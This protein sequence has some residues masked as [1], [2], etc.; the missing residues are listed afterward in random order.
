MVET[1]G[2][3]YVVK[4]KQNPQHR[5]VIINEFV[6]ARLLRR[7]GIASPEF[8]LVR[9]ERR[10]LDDNPE[11]AISGRKGPVPVGVGLHFGSRVPVNP[12]K[13]A[14]F[15][16]I[17]LALLSRVTN[18]AD[19]LKVFVFDLWVDN[20]DGRQAIFFRAGSKDLSALMIDNGFAFGFD[21]TEWRMRDKTICKDRHLLSELYVSEQSARIFE[22]TIPRIAATTAADLEA[23]R[24]S[25]PREWVEDDDEQLSHVFAELN[26]RSQR[27]PI[28]LRQA[29]EGL[30][31]RAQSAREVTPDKRCGPQPGIPRQG[32]FIQTRERIS[33]VGLQRVR[34]RL[35]EEWSDGEIAAAGHQPRP[36]SRA[37]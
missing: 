27:L 21:G 20:N 23:I 18:L 37:G 5:R 9:A 17:P 2:G 34:T 11:V 31:E 22:A 25:I 8:A 13:K 10:F 35:A 3:F 32:N 4:W 7:L 1:S 15:D 30:A 36:F 14:I 12:D 29:L 26:R 28:L 6:A 33:A 19:F 16:F 24:Q